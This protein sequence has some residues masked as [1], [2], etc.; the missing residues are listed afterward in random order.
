MG[1]RCARS[2]V[3]ASSVSSNEPDSDKIASARNTPAVVGGFHPRASAQTATAAASPSG[4]VA[5]DVGIATGICKIRTG[6]TGSENNRNCS[7]TGVMTVTG[8]TTAE[9]SSLS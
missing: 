2:T 9:V 8:E 7:T 3:T 5:V 4:N 6:T 1:D